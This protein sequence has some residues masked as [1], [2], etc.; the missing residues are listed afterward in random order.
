MSDNM[1]YLKADHGRVRCAISLIFI[2]LALG[3]YFHL[4]GTQTAALCVWLII[5]I[6]YCYDCELLNE[7]A[8]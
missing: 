6:H 7:I 5:Q 8:A 2:T 1:A 3:I 4:Q